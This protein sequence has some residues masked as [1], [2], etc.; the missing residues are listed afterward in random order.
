MSTA[1]TPIPSPV[2]PHAVQGPWE[3][4]PRQAFGRQGT[5]SAGGHYC[6]APASEGVWLGKRQPD[7]PVCLCVR[8]AAACRGRGVGR[9]GWE[10]GRVGTASSDRRGRSLWCDTRTANGQLLGGPCSVEPGPRQCAEGTFHAPTPRGPSCTYTALLHS[11]ESVTPFMARLENP[12]LSPRPLPRRG[13]AVRLTL[14]GSFPGFR[15]SWKVT[16][17][18]VALQPCIDPLNLFLD[19]A[20]SS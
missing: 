4:V 3:A 9:R 18:A 12:V 16:Q 20:V 2:S 10:G 15:E 1:G 14:A 13:D 8:S 17:S 6:P 5:A 7:C 19:L 11:N